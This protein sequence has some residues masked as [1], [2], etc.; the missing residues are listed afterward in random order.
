MYKKILVPIMGKYSDELIE[1]ALDLIDRRDVDLYVLYVVDSSVPF[2]TPKNIKK[3]MLVELRAKGGY[4]LDEFE[5][6]LDLSENPNIS[7]TKILKE[8]KPAEIIVKFAEEENIDVIV[9]GTSKNIVAKHFLGSVSEEVVHFAPC[10]IHLV[11]T[12][13]KDNK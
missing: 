11:R 1:H 4:F 7:L 3:S 2:L 12:F 8:G 5:D 13:D 9:M 10:T 6:I